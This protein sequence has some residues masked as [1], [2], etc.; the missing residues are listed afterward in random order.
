MIM[1]EQMCIGLTAA[2]LWYFIQL[3]LEQS[4]LSYRIRLKLRELVTKLILFSTLI[5][6]KESDYKNSITIHIKH[7]PTLWGKLKALFG[8]LFFKKPQPG[9]PDVKENAKEEEAD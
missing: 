2:A 9:I 4:G 8:A 1:F 6:K 7:T 3:I 5:L